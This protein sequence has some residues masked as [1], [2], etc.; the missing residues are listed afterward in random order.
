MGA[1]RDTV[2][3]DA[4][5]NTFG[6]HPSAQMLGLIEETSG[7]RPGTSRTH[8]RDGKTRISKRLKGFPSHDEVRRCFL[9]IGFPCSSQPRCW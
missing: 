9:E 6:A 8:R 5:P 2:A 1:V 7:G 4:Q 3:R